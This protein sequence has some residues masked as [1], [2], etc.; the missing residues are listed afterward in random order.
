MS[1]ARG[2]HG[3][4]VSIRADGAVGCVHLPGACPLNGHDQSGLLFYNHRQNFWVRAQDRL[5]YRI[6]IPVEQAVLLAL[7]V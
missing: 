3:R 5:K 1:T 6:S 7:A 4:G 2:R